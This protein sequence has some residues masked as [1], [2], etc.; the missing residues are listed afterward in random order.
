MSTP[1]QNAVVFTSENWE[2][3]VVHLRIRSP[4]RAAN[5]NVARGFTEASASPDL[6]AIAHAHTVIIQRDFPRHAAAYRAVIQTARTHAK[7]VVYEVDDLMWDMPPDHPVYA[8]F[9]AHHDAIVQAIVDADLVTT[10]AEPLAARLR[11][12][13]PDTVILPNCIDPAIW[14]MKTLTHSDQAQPQQTKVTIGYMGSGTHGPDLQMIEPALCTVMEQYPDRVALELLNEH[15]TPGLARLPNVRRLEGTPNYP[16]YA[17]GFRGRRW[18]IGIAPLRDIPFNRAKSPI[19]YLEFGAIGAAAVLSDLSPYREV[20]THGVNGLL[21]G[22]NE[23]W[24]RALVTL[25]E[26]AAVRERIAANAQND[27]QSRWS[28]A[29]HAHTWQAAFATSQ[30]P[31]S[32][33]PALALPSVSVIVLTHNGKQHLDACFTSLHRQDYPADKLELVLADNA[34]TDGS[35]EYIRTTFPRVRV[36]EVGSNAGFCVAY[37]RAISASTSTYVVLLNDDMR[38]EP[39]WL[40]QLVRAVQSEPNVA[41]AGSKILSWDGTAVDFAGHEYS[42]LGYATG[43]GYGD[44]VLDAHDGQH[45]LFAASGGAMLVQRNAFLDVGGFDENFLAY[46][47]DLDL[48]WRLWSAGY[49]TVYAPRSVAYHKHFST[50]SRTPGPRVAYLYERNTLYA[51]IKNADQ[52]FFERALLPAIMMRLRRAY[53]NGVGAGLRLDHIP[54]RRGQAQPNNHAAPSR[55]GAKHYLRRSVQS[56]RNDGVLGLARSVLDELDRRRG[57]HPPQTLTPNPLI[58]ARLAEADINTF[59]NQDAFWHEQALVAALN[60]VIERYDELLVQRAEIQQRR[61]MR[62]ADIFTLTKALTTRPWLDDPTYARTHHM[63]MACFGLDTA[64]S[65]DFLNPPMSHTAE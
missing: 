46:Y 25:I 40:I 37:N 52:P 30:K 45:Y 57:K 29:A 19:K 24:I 17:D 55:F 47:E 36:F 38:V 5:F 21:A 12:L 32:K 3:A 2:S 28:I 18:D 54:F 23:A 39:N 31:A 64:A 9:A 62:D 6:D 48:G 35:T 16:K 60:D 27:V 1:V 34:S 22:S 43:L 33:A 13:N 11:A 14:Q 42:P 4:L 53:L 65:A 26:D 50:W 59:I 58:D 56:L 8:R 49:K 7:R 41:C 63:L 20:I 10:T 51:L 44:A 15:P 61:V